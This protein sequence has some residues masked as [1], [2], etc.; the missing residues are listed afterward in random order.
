MSLILRCPVCEKHYEAN[1]DIIKSEQLHCPLCGTDAAASD[2]S[3]M[4]FCPHCR[5]KLAVSLDMLTEANLS[6]PRCDKTFVP[7]VNIST[8]T[9]IMTALVLIRV[10][11]P[12]ISVGT[13]LSIFPTNMSRGGALTPSPTS[14]SLTG[15]L[16]NI[17]QR[18]R[19]HHKLLSRARM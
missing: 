8:S 10:K 16:Q 6:C 18:I 4:M 13:I 15:A 14:T 7:T 5:G 12:P 9:E 19:L 11:N 1:D 2:F 3:A 17:L